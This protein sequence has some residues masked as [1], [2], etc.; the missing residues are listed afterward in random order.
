MDIQAYISSGIIEQYVLGVCTPE[1]AASLEQMRIQYPEI[2]DAILEFEQQLEKD[3]Q[4]GAV[5]PDTDTDARILAALEQLTEAPIISMPPAEKGKS[6]VLK[7]IAAASFILLAASAYIIYS[8]VQKT[9][10]QQAA[11][12]QFKNQPAVTTLPLSDYT[13]LTDKTITPVAMYGVGT[14][15]ICRCTMFW[16]KKTGKAYI[17]I[18]HLPQSDDQRDYQLWAYINGK[19][20]SAGIIKDDIRGRFIEMPGIPNG[21]TEFIVTLENAGG[22]QEPTIAETYLRGKI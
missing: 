5:L 11:L 6:S 12:D 19:P 8:L 2:Q 9:K 4:A 10:S 13:I 16:D 14:H 18:H 1:E 15:A 22:T 20:V 7:W 3:L 21:S 17:I